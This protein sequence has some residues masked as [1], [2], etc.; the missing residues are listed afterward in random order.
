MRA[1]T[2]NRRVS[3]QALGSTQDPETGESGDDWVEIAKPWAN[4][5]FLNGREFVSSGVEVSKATVSVRIRYRSGVSAAM[6]VVYRIAIYDIVA[7]LPDESGREFIDL[8]C[9]TGATQG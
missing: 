3:L 8:A 7:V 1:G 6:R 2:L 9:T 5:R 4:I